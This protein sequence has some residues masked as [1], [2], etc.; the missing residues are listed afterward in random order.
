MREQRDEYV[1]N[2]ASWAGRFVSDVVGPAYTA[3]KNAVVALTH[4]PVCA[5]R[6][7][8]SETR[9][10]SQSMKRTMTGS[11]DEHLN[12]ALELLV[13]IEETLATTNMEP[14]LDKHSSL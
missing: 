6:R 3:T 4:Y 1:I 11:V 8:R 10:A 13:F 2:V 7:P 5:G 9:R 14:Q 12:L